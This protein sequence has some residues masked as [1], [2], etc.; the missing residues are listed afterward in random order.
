MSSRASMAHIKVCVVLYLRMSNGLWNVTKMSRMRFATS[1]CISLCFLIFL[2]KSMRPVAAGLVC[3]HLNWS[4]VRTKLIF[5]AWHE[6]DFIFFSENGW[7]GWGK[8]QPS[9]NERRLSIIHIHMYYCL[10]WAATAIKYTMCLCNF[11][12]CIK[13][14]WWNV[15]L[16]IA[17]KRSHR[18]NETKP[19]RCWHFSSDEN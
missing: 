5:V 8:T 9:E 13:L 6:I 12:I 18:K 2:H 10:R 7:R 11:I 16:K 14:V 15:W 17:N 3:L 4:L 1:Y 19:K